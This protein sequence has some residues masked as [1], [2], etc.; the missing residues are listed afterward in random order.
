MR[1]IATYL[2]VKPLGPSDREVGDSDMLDLSS[3]YECLHGLP[4]GVRIVREVF[5]EC[6]L[7]LVCFGGSDGECYWPANN[8]ISV[9]NSI[10]QPIEGTTSRIQE[11]LKYEETYC[12]RYRSRYLTSSF[13]K[14]SSRAAATLD[15]SWKEF[16][17]LLV[18]NN[19]SRGIP[20]SLI[21]S[22]TSS[23]CLRIT[24]LSVGHPN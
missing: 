17:N 19:S 7:E 2:L 16:H 4:G 1:G 22:P 3:S 10:Q 9:S 21:P 23:S 12:M 8:R 15:G 6:R 14:V 5:I 24:N 13:C 18:M 20:A 11:E